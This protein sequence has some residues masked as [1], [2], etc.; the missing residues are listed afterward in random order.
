MTKEKEPVSEY[1]IKAQ[2]LLRQ[3]D[4]LSPIESKK[5][6]DQLKALN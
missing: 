6:E 3:I 2:K 1:L 4:Q 5:A